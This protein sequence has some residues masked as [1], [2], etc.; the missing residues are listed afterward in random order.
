VVFNGIGNTVGIR[1]MCYGLGTVGSTEEQ[2][3]LCCTADSTFLITSNNYCLLLD[4]CLLPTQ[5]C[6]DDAA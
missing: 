2:I 6:I 5:T 3:F 4:Q 1:N